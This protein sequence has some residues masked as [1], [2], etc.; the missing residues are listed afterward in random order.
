MLL[1]AGRKSYLEYFLFN[2]SLQS[3]NRTKITS[4]NT[5][6]W[7]GR[8]R[9][10]CALKSQPH[11][12]KCI[13]NHQW[14]QG[15]SDFFPWETLRFLESFSRPGMEGSINSGGCGLEKVAWEAKVEVVPP[16]LRL[17]P[18]LGTHDV[19]NILGLQLPPAPASIAH[20]Q[21]LWEL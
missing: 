2:F 12:L 14:N 18:L 17:A 16:G 7:S 9:Q 10:M 4:R 21:R 3:C 1:F 19:P 11:Q 20:G 8:G 6:R 13:S 15:L 5:E